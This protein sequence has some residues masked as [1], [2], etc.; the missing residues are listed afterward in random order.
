MVSSF[1]AHDGL[2]LASAFTIYNSKPI[3]VTGGNDHTIDIWDIGVCGTPSTTSERTNNGRRN[4]LFHNEL[5]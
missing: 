4:S 1:R 2:I 5:R 3:F